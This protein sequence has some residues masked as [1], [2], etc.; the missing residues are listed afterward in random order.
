MST[1]VACRSQAIFNASV[2]LDGL[3]IVDAQWIDGLT[4]SK[5]SPGAFF[6]TTYLGRG[7]FSHSLGASAGMFFE[8]G[9]TAYPVFE[10]PS[11]SPSNAA[12]RAFK[13]DQQLQI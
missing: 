13:S 12:L 2:A 9:E 4:L 6:L 1:V 7:P 8:H 10:I 5:A 11:V 3:P